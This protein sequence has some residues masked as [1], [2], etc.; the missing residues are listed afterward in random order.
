MQKLIIFILTLLS[1]RGYSAH[2]ALTFDDAP[3]GDMELYTGQERTQILIDILGKYNIQTVFFSNSIKMKKY[4]GL[5]RMKMYDKAGHI[6][7]NHT[8]AH[9]DFHKVSIEDYIFNFNKAD[10]LL[11]R[12]KNFRPWFRYPFLRQGDTVEKRD[13][14]RSHL[15]KMGYRNGYVTLDIQDWFMADLVNSAIKDGKKINEPKLCRAY[16]EMIWDTMVYYDG[17]AR[18]ILKRSPKHMLLL[19]ENDL[20]ALCLE[21]LIREIKS[22]GWTIISPEEAIKDEIYNE[23]PNTLFNGNGQIAALYHEAKGIKLFDPWSYPWEGGK[24]IRKE[25]SRRRVFG[26]K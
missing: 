15:D 16:S 22:N 20:A 5:E 23:R 19:H 8:H 18:D 11:K 25:F 2:V 4:N 1:L 13:A 26:N 24:L 14:M 17:K 7:A 21:N 12:F 9:P 6:I 10:S 3:M